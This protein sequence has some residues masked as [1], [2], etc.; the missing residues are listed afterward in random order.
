MKRHLNE[1]IFRRQISTRRELKQLLLAALTAC[2]LKINV[3]VFEINRETDKKKEKKNRP[4][5][6]RTGVTTKQIYISPVQRLN[7][8]R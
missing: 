2:F 5:L 4:T 1:C 3:L 8:L 6:F 7:R